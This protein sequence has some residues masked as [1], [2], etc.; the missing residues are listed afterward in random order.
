[1]YGL[2]QFAFGIET[3]D[4]KW[5]DGEAFP[6][7]KNTLVIENGYSLLPEEPQAAASSTLHLVTM[8]RLA[9]VKGYDR[10]IRSMAL[11]RIHIP[12]SVLT[13]IGKGKQE[14]ELKELAQRLGLG[15]AVVFSGFLADPFPALRNN[16]IFVLTSYM[17]GFP[18]ALIEA[19][20]CG[21][22]VVAADCRSGPREILS[23]VYTPE[24]VRGI[25]QEKYGVLVDASSD[26]FE[27]R[28][29]QAVIQL[30]TDKQK[31]AY[32]RKNGFLRAEDFSLP[33][34][35]EKLE[36]LLQDLQEKKPI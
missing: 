2:Y 32:Y 36:K 18:N 14:S 10:L 19:L 5:V 22:P 4:M 26:G 1:M 24:P 11:I 6:E 27:D 30:W 31:M 13:I 29:A 28:F 34:Y 35:Q 8:C 20:N 25:R 12:D 9:P 17:E 16:H 33:R 3:V 23:G 7:L 15:D 21:L